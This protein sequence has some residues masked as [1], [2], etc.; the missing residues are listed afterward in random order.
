MFSDYFEHI[1]TH[2]HAFGRVRMHV[3]AFGGIWTH[4]KFLDTRWA[5][6]YATTLFERKRA[7]EVPEGPLKTLFE[8]KGSFEVP[9]VL[10]N[11]SACSASLGLRKPSSSEK[12]RSKRL[13]GLRKILSQRE[14]GHF[15][16]ARASASGQDA[17]EP[18]SRRGLLWYFRDGFVA[19]FG[20]SSHVL[21]SLGK[22]L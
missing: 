16:R 9:P 5:C 10:P 13:W 21:S 3:S 22:I 14:R 20:T 1:R 6:G 17:R 12:A 4:R 2:S 15:E 11:R 8:Q 18:R 19:D 7:P